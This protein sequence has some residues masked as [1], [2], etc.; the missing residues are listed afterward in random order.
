[1]VW[2]STSAARHTAN[3]RDFSTVDRSRV[4]DDGGRSVVG[5][6]LMTTQ[7]RRVLLVSRSLTASLVARLCSV[8]PYARGTLLRLRDK[9]LKPSEF[10]QRSLHV[11]HSSPRREKTFIGLLRGATS[12][13]IRCLTVPL[14]DNHPSR[15]AALSDHSEVARR[16][17]S[18]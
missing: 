5:F 13:P 16:P 18:P 12:E 4:L 17:L 8:L 2:L 1:M 6:G 7:H 11:R 14:I 3:P 15:W 10:S 9:S